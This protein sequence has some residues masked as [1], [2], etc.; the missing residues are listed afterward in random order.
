MDSL[1]LDSQDPVP[2]QAR[3]SFLSR[4]NALLFNTTCASARA[5]YPSSYRYLVV[6]FT[7]SFFSLFSLLTLSLLL[8]LLLS[9]RL[10]PVV[11]ISSMSECCDVHPLAVVVIQYHTNFA[12]PLPLHFSFNV[13]LA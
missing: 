7:F 8:S 3:Y 12:V 1:F 5:P 9:C 4:K 2:S 10:F 11:H 13:P 6:C